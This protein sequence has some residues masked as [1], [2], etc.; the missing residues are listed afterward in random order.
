MKRGRKLVIGVGINDAD[1]VVK[2]MESWQEGGKLKQRQTWVCPFYETWKSML[3]RAYSEKWWERHPTY[4]GVTVCREWHR[5]S[6]FREWMINQ[7]YEGKQLDKDILDPSNKE[8]T[9]EKCVF[10]SKLV[11]TFILDRCNNRGC[12]PLG[13]CY[14][15]SR[16]H[17]STPYLAQC[18]NPFTGKRDRLGWYATPTQAHSAW[19]KHK[20][21]LAVQLSESEHVTDD[22]VGAAIIKRYCTTFG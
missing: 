17:L 8:Y 3:T 4:K 11:N 16:S 10:V 22:R 15:K 6:V 7:D 14:D 1:Y 5:F 18:S 19:K 12:Y 21:K 9:P 2:K 20:L 13:V